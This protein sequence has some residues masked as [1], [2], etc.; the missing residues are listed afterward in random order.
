MHQTWSNKG[1]RVASVICL[2]LLKGISALKALWDGGM[3]GDTMA[4]MIHTANLTKRLSTVVF[5][6]AGPQD[7]QNK[8][9]SLGILYSGEGLIRPLRAL[10]WPKGAKGP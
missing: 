8:A 2:C 1:L 10:A 6:Q 5:P 7:N 3:V 9:K 4:E